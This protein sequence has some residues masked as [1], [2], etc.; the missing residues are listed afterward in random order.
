[1]P[2]WSKFRDGP[3][4]R[5]TRN[6]AARATGRKREDANTETGN[7]GG[8]GNKAEETSG[9]RS[10]NKRKQPPKAA[11]KSRKKVKIAEPSSEQAAEAQVEHS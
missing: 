11:T 3:A 9:T 5:Q 7:G 2:P 6:A 10:S 8:A 4:P 1:M